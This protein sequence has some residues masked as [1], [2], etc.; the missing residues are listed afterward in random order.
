MTGRSESR[1]VKRD[2]FGIEFGNSIDEGDNQFL[3]RPFSDVG[4]AQSRHFP[5]G[6]VTPSNQ[7]SDADYGM[8]NM[9]GKFISHCLA[10]LVVG[11]AVVSIGGGKASDV[12]SR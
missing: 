10:N 5:M 6:I 4:C 8:E 1:A 3:F 9:L 2:Q 7:R 11:L 12:S